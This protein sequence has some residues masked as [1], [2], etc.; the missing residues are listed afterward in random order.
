MVMSLSCLAAA[1]AV[2]LAPGTAA[3]A[4]IHGLWPTPARRRSWRP[5]A[6]GPVALGAIGGLLLAGPGGAVAGAVVAGTARGRHRHR[7]GAHHAADTCEQLADAVRRMAEELRAGTHPTAALAGITSDGPQARAV[8]GPAAVAAGLGDD[9]PAAL[10]RAAGEHPAVA[11]D[12][13]RIAGAWELSTRHGVPLAGLLAGAQE[14]IRWQVRFTRTV[15]AQLAGPRATATVLTALPVLGL[16]LGQLVGADPIGVLRSGLLGQVLVVVGV[17]L[18]AAGSAWTERIIAA[19]T[20][21]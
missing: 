14:H 17:A 18:A 19:A 1:A 15:G 16:G 8:L 10:R 11:G 21:R 12:V 6:L 4:R 2:L 13:E 7:R 3:R 5:A 9:V 20:P